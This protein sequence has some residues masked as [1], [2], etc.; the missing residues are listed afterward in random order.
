LQRFVFSLG[1]GAAVLVAVVLTAAITWAAPATATPSSPGPGSG[2]EKLWEQFPLDAEGDSSGAGGVSRD[3]GA[4][5]Q[6]VRRVGRVVPHAASG[7]A[8]PRELEIVA[9][10]IVLLLGGVG[11][12][13]VRYGQAAARRRLTAAARRRRIRVAPRR[14]VGSSLRVAA[15][16]ALDEIRNLRVLSR[17][18]SPAL[19]VLT[20]TGSPKAQKSS[21]SDLEERPMVAP[22]SRPA[23]RPVVDRSARVLS[24]SP[25]TPTPGQKTMVKA[26]DG[27]GLVSETDVLKAK[28]SVA[29][30]LKLSKA[31]PLV[32]VEALRRKPAV[33]A[34]D[35]VK[36]KVA[37]EA[38]V[39]KERLVPNS[40]LALKEKLTA[41]P[42]REQT[43]DPPIATRTRQRPPA[44][45]LHPIAELGGNPSAAPDAHASAAPSQHLDPFGDHFIGT[46]RTQARRFPESLGERGISIGYLAFGFIAA[47]TAGVFAVFIASLLS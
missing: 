15:V 46:A 20:S 29:D 42:K 1:I 16:A 7:E 24:A 28:S 38:A 37:K 13:L 3:P 23:E 26:N 12:V 44:S 17:L 14:Q 21:A 18:A 9:T 34:M 2:P 33:D 30:S 32:E 4:G 22:R 45:L 19:L 8:G 31:L 47:V 40:T 11:A 35:V 27:G 25:E 39:D 36:T 43:A 41:T 5:E 6:P 10:A